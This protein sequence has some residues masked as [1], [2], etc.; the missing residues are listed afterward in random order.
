MVEVQ[1]LK[2]RIEPDS[3]SGD[4]ICNAKA[5]HFQPKAQRHR[6]TRSLSSSYGGAGK[7]PRIHGTFKSLVVFLSLTG[8]G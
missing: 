4:K 2:A 8:V 3:C 7:T 6:S 5:V 1:S